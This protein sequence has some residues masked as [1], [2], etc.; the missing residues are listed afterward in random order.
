MK[1]ISAT[2]AATRIIEIIKESDENKDSEDG[3]SNTEPT[4]QTNQAYRILI[5][6]WAT[7]KVY[8][9]EI[10]LTDPSN[11]DMIDEK[12]TAVQA[13]LKGTGT[14]LFPTAH[15]EVA[16]EGDTNSALTTTL[17]SNLN[18]VSCA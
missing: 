15:I 1:N 12:Q 13:E 9:K 17:I 2:A 14:S 6:L 7:A 4:S 11:M 3:E 5:F 10:L 16:E 8:H 18:A